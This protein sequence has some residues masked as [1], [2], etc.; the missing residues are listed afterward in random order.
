VLTSQLKSTSLQ[1][2]I[3]DESKEGAVFLDTLC[4]VPQQ[5]D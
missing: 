5:S 4:E 1:D 3:E 2:L